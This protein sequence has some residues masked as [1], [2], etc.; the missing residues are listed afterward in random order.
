MN[1]AFDCQKSLIVEG[2]PSNTIHI[3]GIFSAIT[4]FESPHIPTETHFEIAT[5]FSIA[6]NFRPGHHTIVLVTGHSKRWLEML[7]DVDDDLWID[8]AVVRVLIEV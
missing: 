8:D 5:A 1:S 6:P 2:L 7:V 3:D 4:R